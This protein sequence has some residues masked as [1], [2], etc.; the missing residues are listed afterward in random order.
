MLTRAGIDNQATP[1]RG[2]R[3][4]DRHDLAYWLLGS[5]PDRIVLEATD[6]GEYLARFTG[7]FSG[8]NDVRGAMKCRAS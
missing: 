2:D 3:D 5:R 4:R 6:A 7:Q 1:L 8:W